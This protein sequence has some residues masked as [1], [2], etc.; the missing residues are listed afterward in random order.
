MFSVIIPTMWRSMR[1]LGM[2]HRLYNSD[3]VDEII[4]IDNDKDSRF[5]FDNKKIKLLEQEENIFVNPAWNLGVNECKNENICILNDD[6]TFD[7]DEVFGTA[8]RFLSDHPSSCLGVHPVSYQGY[9][10][11]IKVAEGSAI[12]QGWGC[13]IFLRKESWVDIPDQIKIWFGDNWIVW[14]YEK[15]FSAAFQISTEMST[16]SNLDELSDVIKQDIEEW[17]KI[18]NYSFSI[19]YINHDDDVFNRFLGPSLNSLKGNFEV[20]CTSDKKRPAKNY[21]EIIDKSAFNFIILTHQDVSF[22]SDLLERISL[23]IKSVGDWSALAMVGVSEDGTY[24]W[25]NQ[26][27]SFEVSS[28]DCCFILINK[29]HGIR[30]DE[31]LFDDFHLYVENYCGQVKQKTGLP[32]RTILTNSKESSPYQR[33]E[34]LTTYLNHHSVTVNKRGTAWGKYWEYRKKLEDKWPGIKTT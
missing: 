31:K 1:L 16:T 23:T 12:A 10:D 19:G 22:S 3:Y 34:S 27:R 5:S 4:I 20:V 13:C 9:N 25:S 30:F 7:V 15:S 21:N 6:V 24:R 28:A 32:V 17:Y 8:T 33:D 2:L 14:N 26:D 11:S 18:S 29:D